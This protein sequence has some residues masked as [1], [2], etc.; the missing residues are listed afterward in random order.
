MIVHNVCKVICGNSGLLEDDSILIVLR[1]VES[2]SDGVL[3][4]DPS[5]LVLRKVQISVGLKPY[6]EFLAGIDLSLYLFV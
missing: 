6:Y 2:A 1:H 4:L 5:D 3:H